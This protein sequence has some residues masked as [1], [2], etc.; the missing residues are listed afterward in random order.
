MKLVLPEWRTGVAEYLL[1][2]IVKQRTNQVSNGH[3][4]TKRLV[5]AGYYNILGRYESQNLC[6]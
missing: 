1:K 4:Q 2:P 5:L 6:D 3:F